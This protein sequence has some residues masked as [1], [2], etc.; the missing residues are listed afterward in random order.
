MA[1]AR[2]ENNNV[3]YIDKYITIE[4]IITDIYKENKNYKDMIDDTI[5]YKMITVYTISSAISRNNKNKYWLYDKYDE[6]WNFSI[7]PSY[8]SCDYFTSINFD[9][10]DTKLQLHATNCHKCGNYKFLSKELSIIR[11]DCLK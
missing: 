11:C 2:E 8:Q 4:K 5:F 1:L 10:N 7:T 3:N 6:Y 9:N